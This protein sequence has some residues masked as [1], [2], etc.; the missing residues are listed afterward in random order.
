MATALRVFSSGAGVQ[1]I[2]CL[3]LCARGEINY[4]VHLFC[5][6]GDD[7]EDPATLAYA[8]GHAAPF[9]RANGIE[10]HELRRVKR[11][12]TTETLYQRL[13]RENSRSLPIPVRMN[14]TGAPGTR[15]CTADF[16][17]KVIEKWIK[18]RGASAANPAITGIGISLDEWQRMRDSRTDFQMLEYPLVALRI[19]RAGC[20]RIIAQAGLPLPP[21]SACYFCPFHT[22][23]DWAEMRKA[24]PDL[25]EKAAAL[26]S[27]LNDRRARLGKDPVWFS[28]RLKPLNKAI[29][30]D[31][32]MSL[33]PAETENDC[34][35]FVCDR[36]ATYPTKA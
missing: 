24:R 22:L 11:D 29:P 2:A 20:E 14:D 1:S 9:A 28:G 35:P 32:Q 34:G 10:W 25:F 21:K 15:S 6:V 12:G 13:A 18:A 19:T 27:L 33:F 3:V 26:E 30:E 5:N 36:G 4:P 7:S 16:K 23:R 8:R 17:I 31:H